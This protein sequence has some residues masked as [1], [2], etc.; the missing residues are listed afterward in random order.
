MNRIVFVEIC[1]VCSEQ[2]MYVEAGTRVD[3]R[4]LFEL[5]EERLLHVTLTVSNGN[6][7]YSRMSKDA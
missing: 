6:N 3:V 4:V 1:I 5:L 2:Y 7:I